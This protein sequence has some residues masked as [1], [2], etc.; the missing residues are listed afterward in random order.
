MNLNDDAW[1]KLFTK[2]HILDCIQKYGYF[3]IS[4]QQIKEFRE[5]RLMTKFDHKTNLPSI[6][7]QFK[8]AILPITR[9][10][11]MISSFE[12]YKNFEAPDPANTQKVSIPDYIQSLMPQFLTSEAIA[13]NCAKACGILNDFLEDDELTA[14]VS[15][16]MGSGNF[17]FNINTHYGPKHIFVR[18][19]QIEIDAAYEG[20]KYL[21]LF[22]AKRD[23]A[24]DFLVRQLD[25]PFRVWSNRVT[26]IVKPVFLIF[27]TGTFYLYQYEFAD[28]T[29]YN[30]LHLVKQKNYI[31]EAQ[32]TLTDIEEILNKTKLAKEPQLPFPQAD[33][34]SRII[35]LMELLSKQPLRKQDITA[36]FAF[37][38][39]QADYYTNA[40]RYLNLIIKNKDTNQFQLSPLGQKI[41][42]MDYKN[43]QLSIV[44]QIV[45]HNVFNTVLKMHLQSGEMPSKAVVIHIMKNSHLYI[46]NHSDPNIMGSDDTYSRRSS[47]V[48]GWVKWILGII[49]T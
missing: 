8:L 25:Y 35:N 31:I 22:E 36:K 4:A 3:T 32:I 14:T 11:Y 49:S 6:F 21:S 15:G 40:G 12:A 28:P 42:D 46:K 37:A 33:R 2:Y 23:L 18:N 19:S 47:T 29:N 24:D 30:S 39:R 7:R 43:R 34:M 45:S 20:I 9:G 41:M 26:K 1:E 27:S 17:D 44:Q 16:R 10:D 38:P 5:P 13:L 48:I